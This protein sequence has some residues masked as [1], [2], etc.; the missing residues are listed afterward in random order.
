M[1]STLLRTRSRSSLK[2]REMWWLRSAVS[3]GWLLRRVER[4]YESII[5]ERRH[6]TS[7]R[8]HSFGRLLRLSRV[9]PAQQLQLAFRIFDQS[10]ARFDPIA[11]IAVERLAD[12]TEIGPV[13]V[14][15]QDAVET[16]FGGMF[17]GQLLEAL[18]V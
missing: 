2:R 12:A 11:G 18:D 8:L 10:R 7:P 1:A 9:R 17:R 3:I 6:A 14:A 13:D 16:L 15:A 5:A 4:P